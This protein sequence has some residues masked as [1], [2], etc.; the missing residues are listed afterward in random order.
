MNS[1]DNSYLQRW[2]VRATHRRNTDR[3]KNCDVWDLCTCIRWVISFWVSFL[4]RRWCP[5]WGPFLRQQSCPPP[6]FSKAIVERRKEWPEMQKAE[7]YKIDSCVDVSFSITRM[8]R[9]IK[10]WTLMEDLHK[11]WDSWS[12]LIL[13][14]RRRRIEDAR[15]VHAVINLLY[16]TASFLSF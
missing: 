12:S 16:I 13:S 3:P 5:D 4:L 8:Y 10:V 2:W 14:R 9:L 15:I 7:D 11:L 1:L 6:N